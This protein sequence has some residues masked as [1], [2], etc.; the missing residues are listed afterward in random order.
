MK[1]HELRYELP[2]EL[3]ARVPAEPR[4]A[5]RLLV[6]G[7]SHAALHH[8]RF[9]DIPELLKPGDLLVTNN[10]RVVPARFFCNR[11]SG[12]RIEGLFLRESPDGWIV[13][14]KPA[15]RLRSGEIVQV[16]G[17]QPPCRL[18]L[19][20]R[21][22]RG[23]W[24]VVPIEPRNAATV[25]EQA[26]EVPLPPY[27]RASR[28]DDARAML[29]SAD[30]ERYQTVYAE[31][32]GSVAAPTAGL[33]FTAEVL[34]KLADRKIRRACV[35]LH[36]GLGTFAPLDVDDLTQHKI[37]S[38]TYCIPGD[39][40]RAIRETKAAGGRVIA[41]GTTACR[42][43]ESLARRPEWAAAAP[44]AD[45][46]DETALFL[47]PPATFHIVDALITNFHLPE[48]TLLALVMAF[49]SPERIRAA[50]AEAI[51]ERYRFYSFGDAMLIH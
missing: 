5:S 42:T 17:S 28:R 10:S 1:R 20:A 23:E 48:S 6:M 50:Y 36:V 8:H 32:P 49:S 45:I 27:I 21:G 43:L 19:I 4:D 7:R 18:R 47:Y 26:G 37:H 33:H 16:I 24:R 38:E 44:P 12:G 46:V 30:R 22:A 13:L 51:R 29:E 41:V 2:P 39:T 40:I 31:V 34:S 25:L 14:L 11:S 9:R 35:T 3:I 15:S